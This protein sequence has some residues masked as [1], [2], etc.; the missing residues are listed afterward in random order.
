MEQI[1][2]ESVKQKSSLKEMKDYNESL[3]AE[4]RTLKE[5]MK[6]KDM[7]LRLI[8]SD[9]AAALMGKEKIL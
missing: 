3:L 2:K 4:S 1:Q 9:C 5:M 8:K 7:D 6:E